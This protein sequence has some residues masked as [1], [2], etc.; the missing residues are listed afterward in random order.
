MLK[1]ALHLLAILVFF[2]A[3]GQVRAGEPIVVFAPAPAGGFHCDLPAP[4][5]FHLTGGN[6]TLISL[7]WDGVQ[8]A[9]DYC[10]EV[11][12]YQTQDLILAD[13]TSGLNINLPMASPVAVTITV[14]ARAPG[15]PA[16]RRKA[17]IENFLPIIAELI[18]EHTA[19]DGIQQ[20]LDDPEGDNCFDVEWPI[21]GY[22]YGF[23]IIWN[24]EMFSLRAPYDIN[25]NGEG[26][27]FCEANMELG[28]IIP[29]MLNS[30]IFGLNS[31][32]N[33]STPPF[34]NPNQIVVKKYNGVEYEDWVYIKISEINPV[35]TSFCFTIAPGFQG[36]GGQEGGKSKPTS[37]T[38]IRFWRQ[39]DWFANAPDNRNAA[40]ETT[41]L[42][43]K[44]LVQN[45]FSDQLRIQ[46]QDN[47]T[48][49]P[50]RFQLFNLNGGLVLEQEYSASQEYI[51]PTS[52]LL[53]GL[54]LLRMDAN[55]AS[56]TYRVV[57]LP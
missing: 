1:K 53:S 37:V 21:E 38:T 46:N 56:Q 43:Q 45:P 47:T 16:S 52:D 26:S 24:T 4:S 19:P 14:A 25:Y 30:Q 55:G 7:A 9:G 50:V 6:G 28:K 57:K 40:P 27:V 31:S 13:T 44:T 42:N 3:V 15:C 22:H 29:S 41:D 23:D 5:N 34:C 49:G 36:K 18:V 20:I 8:G 12:N 35:I 2:L 32:G 54:Y 10:L 33:W 11:R 39:E 17:S 48:T 51:L